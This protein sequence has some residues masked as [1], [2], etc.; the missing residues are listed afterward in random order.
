MRA[1]LYGVV[2]ALLLGAM[3]LGIMLVLTAS[4]RSILTNYWS[5]LEVLR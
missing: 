5:V 1:Q 4:L 3:C 2:L